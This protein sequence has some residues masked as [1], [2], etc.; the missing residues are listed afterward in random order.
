[1]INSS[2]ELVEAVL[3]VCNV[4]GAIVGNTSLLS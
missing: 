1:M 4:K 3:I 2:S